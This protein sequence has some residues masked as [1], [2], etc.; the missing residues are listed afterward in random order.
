VIDDEATICDMVREVLAADGHEVTVARDGQAGLDRILESEYDCV[1]AD[2]KMPELDGP[3]LHAELVERVP[4]LARRVVFMT[5]DTLSEESRGFLESIG[6]TYLAK[7]F[8]ISALR[9]AVQASFV[10][11]STADPNPVS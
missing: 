7:P 2:V 10:G 6:N 3:S 1:L 4:E 9:Q 5:G 8:S 11:K